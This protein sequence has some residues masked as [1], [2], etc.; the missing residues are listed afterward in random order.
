MSKISE[1]YLDEMEDLAFE[2][3]A[4]IKKAF[5]TA[6][7]DPAAKYHFDMAKLGLGQ[8]GAY[9]RARATEANMRQIELVEQRM[10]NREEARE[11]PPMLSAGH[12][13]NA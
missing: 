13:D 1:R 8:I 11:L 2:S 4:K 10:L 6:R 12:Q 5:G 3:M 9:V 7:S